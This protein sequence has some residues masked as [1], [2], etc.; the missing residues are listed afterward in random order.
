MSP[1]IETLWAGRAELGEG[2]V[3]DAA[4]GRLYWTDIIGR[5]LYRMD[6]LGGPVAGWDMPAPVGSVAVTDRGDLLAAMGTGFA[7]IDPRTGAVEGLDLG[8]RAPDTCLMNDGKPDRFGAFVCGAKELGES[9]PIAPAF[10]VSDGRATPLAARFTVFN[11]PAFSPEGRVVYFADSPTR[12][13]RRASY[14][15]ATGAFGEPMVFARLDPDAGYP[16]GMTVDA[17]GCLWNAHWDGARLT[18]Y[19]PDGS[20]DRGVDMPVRR[21]TSV[22]FA[23]PDL[24]RLIVTS[25]A[26][27]R[28]AGE[29]AAGAVTVVDGLGVTGLAET[30]VRL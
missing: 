7:R 26:K 3:W 14:D 8:A 9:A 24:D 23:G 19:R 15:P 25:A 21:P 5:R 13:I 28:P 12:E 6:G 30:P 16:D 10:R 17:E 2:P 4:T 20:V 29:A 18:R 27:D 1:R 22:A 11:G